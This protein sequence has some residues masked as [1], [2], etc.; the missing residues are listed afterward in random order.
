MTDLVLDTHTSFWYLANDARLSRL[1]LKTIR[2]A[3]SA[4]KRCFVPSIC[5]VE[6][7]YL[8]ERNRIPESSY[9]LLEDALEN[10][11][12]NL[13][14]SPLDFLVTRAIG[15]I[16]RQEVPDLPDRVIAATALALGLPLVTRDGKIR[17]SGI[18]TVW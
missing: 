10:P 14:I 13:A 17:A 4:R 1:A 8:V 3:V 2:A 12:S 16:P 9:R 11:E 6:A 18:K 5:L 15:R 7:T